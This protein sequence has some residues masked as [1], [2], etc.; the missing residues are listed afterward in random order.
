MRERE[1]GVR[2]VDE[3]QRPPKQEKPS[4]VSATQAPSGWL[5]RTPATWFPQFH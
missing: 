3:A 5:Q 2:E 4:R 1:A